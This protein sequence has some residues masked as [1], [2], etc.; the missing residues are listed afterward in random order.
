[1]QVYRSYTV[2]TR[3]KLGRRT[4]FIYNNHI[5]YMY[6]VYT[7]CLYIVYML[8]YIMFVCYFFFFAV[9]TFVSKYL[10]T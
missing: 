3:T 4:A 1:M 8:H 6:N 7:I 2:C 10:T 5:A 9:F